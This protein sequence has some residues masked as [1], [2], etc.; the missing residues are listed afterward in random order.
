MQHV[1]PWF[2]DMSLDG[3]QT[4]R[5][6]SLRVRQYANCRIDFACTCCTRGRCLAL[7]RARAIRLNVR[8]QNVPLTSRVLSLLLR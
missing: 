3:R 2:A 5:S 6:D 8:K 1:T 4:Q 7:A